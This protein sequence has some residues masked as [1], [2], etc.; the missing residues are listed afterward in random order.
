[1]EELVGRL[2]LAPHII[3]VGLDGEEAV[4][5]DRAV[6]DHFGVRHASGMI[7]RARGGE[8]IFGG[9]VCR[10]GGVQ[11]DSETAYGVRKSSEGQ[12]PRGILSY[13]KGN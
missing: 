12:L 8:G 2:V 3:Y 13:C 6:L 1:L 4:S 5:M 10:G 7:A 9:C 11:W